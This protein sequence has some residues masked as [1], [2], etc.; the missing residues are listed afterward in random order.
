MRNLGEIKGELAILKITSV[1]INSDALYYSLGLKS[2]KLAA[3]ET[4]KWVLG[5]I[6]KPMSTQI[7]EGLNEK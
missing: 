3:I 1:P 7:L 5:E 4:L 2:G 6:E